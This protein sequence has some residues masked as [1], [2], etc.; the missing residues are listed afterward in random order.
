M[1]RMG[2]KVL[3]PVTEGEFS[4]T[5]W[6]NNTIIEL[7]GSYIF[8]ASDTWF[9]SKNLHLGQIKVAGLFLRNDLLH[10]W[11]TRCA[12]VDESLKCHCQTHV[13]DYIEIFP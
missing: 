3:E 9:G 12:S 8:W 1:P 7:C 6:D 10:T 4:V 11:L 13:A 2:F 5:K